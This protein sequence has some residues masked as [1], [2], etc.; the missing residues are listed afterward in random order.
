[1]VAI[2]LDANSIVGK[3]MMILYAG[4]PGM[5][6][7]EPVDKT[8]HA[9]LYVNFP[10]RAYLGRALGMSNRPAQVWL[11]GLGVWAATNVAP[12][13]EEGSCTAGAATKA[14]A[15][16]IDLTGDDSPN[17]EGEPCSICAWRR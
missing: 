1:M 12:R 6:L 17:R 8:G 3:A 7:P 2:L 9:I 5:I 16:V 14:D 4:A 11:P 10:T 13:G 15:C